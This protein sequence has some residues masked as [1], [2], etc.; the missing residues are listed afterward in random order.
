MKYL[1][2]AFIAAASLGVVACDEPTPSPVVVE[3]PANETPVIND[4]C[5]PGAPPLGPNEHCE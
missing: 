5:A 2:L 3:V 4:N 1:P